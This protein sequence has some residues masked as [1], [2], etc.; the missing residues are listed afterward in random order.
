MLT[1]TWS[2]RRG[3]TLPL[4]LLVIAILTLSM[5]VAASRLSSE[6]QITSDHEAV[7]DAFAVAQ[8]GMEQYLSGLTALPPGTV[9]PITHDSTI[10]NLPGG[11]ALVSFRRLRDSTSTTPAI[12]VVTSRGTN[13]GAKRFGFRVGAAE[14]TVAQYAVWRPADLDLNA[15]FTSLSGVDKNGNSGALDGNDGCGGAPAIPGVAVPGGTYTGHTNPIN[16][17]PDNAPISLGTPGTAGTAKDAVEVDWA[18]I[19]AGTAIPATYTIPGVAWPTAAQMANW[20]VIRV[21]GDLNL[22]GGST[23]GKGILIVTGN[24]TVGGSWRH[25]GIVLVGGVLTSNGNNTIQGA[26]ITALNIKLGVAVPQNAVANGNKTFQ[27]NSCSIASALKRIGSVQR[28]RNAWTDTWSS[29]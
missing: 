23:D 17:N 11:T 25:D 14:R 9:P 21:N 26:V 1:P 22:A 3:A 10:T 8:A 13:T 24:M 18:G 19:V 28:V 29:Y 2:E 20:P 27:Y 4:S 5:M 16:G 12:Y 6:R 15:A 7:M